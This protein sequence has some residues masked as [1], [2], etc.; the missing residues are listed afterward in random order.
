M[1]SWLICTGL[2]PR[3]LP[4]RGL[5]IRA[6]KNESHNREIH[7]PITIAELQYGVEIASDPGIRQARQRSVDILKKKPILKIDEETGSIYGRLAVE[8]HRIGK[9]SDYRVMY[10]W[11]AA[12]ALQ[13]NLTLLT[14]NIKDFKDVPG[15]SLVSCN[16]RFARWPITQKPDRVAGGGSGFRHSA[17]YRTLPPFG[18]RP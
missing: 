2:F 16:I 6:K 17:Y 15:L 14:D 13:F 5:R 11:L 7:S 12:Q 18:D 1:R 4:N 3:Q 10:L 8:L 9:Q